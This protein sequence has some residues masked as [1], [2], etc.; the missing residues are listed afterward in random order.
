MV[1]RNFS[2]SEYSVEQFCDDM[3]MSRSSLYKSEL[4]KV[5]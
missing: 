3:G 5:H 2:D 4:S 1:E